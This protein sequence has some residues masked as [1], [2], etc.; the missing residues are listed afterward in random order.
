MKALG[1]AFFARLD[2]QMAEAD[3]IIKGRRAGNAWDALA[4]I[5]AEF[6]SGRVV[7]RGETQAA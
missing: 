7:L 5:V 1:R 4:L 3:R 6:A 2:M